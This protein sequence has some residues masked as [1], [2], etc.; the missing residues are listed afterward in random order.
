MNGLSALALID[1]LCGSMTMCRIMEF[2]LNNLEETD[3]LFGLGIIINAGCIEIKN[4]T[5]KNLLRR[6]NIPDSIQQFFPIQTASIS[7]Q[8]SI[9]QC[10]TFNDVLAEALC[11][12]LAEAGAYDGMDAVA[13]GNDDVEVIIKN[14]MFLSFS[15]NGSMRSGYSEFPN[16]HGFGQYHLR[17]LEPLKGCRLRSHEKPFTSGQFPGVFIRCTLERADGKTEKRTFALRNDRG[18]GAWTVDGGL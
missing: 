10:K 4:L 9:I 12:P 16:N 2:V 6:P 8:P 18:Y 5:I 7:L 15:F 13:D 1:Y 17:T 14:V 3:R 11:R